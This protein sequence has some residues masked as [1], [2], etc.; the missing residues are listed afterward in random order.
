VQEF[1]L[2]ASASSPAAEPVA[3]VAAEVETANA[4]EPEPQSKSAS[5]SSDW[6]ELAS[7]E[8][9]SEPG[10]A[11]VEQ[12]SA[13]LDDEAFAEILEE[14]RF[15]LMHGLRAEAD[16]A[17]R[18][19]EQMR[20]GSAEVAQVRAEY[21]ASETAAPAETEATDAELSVASAELADNSVDEAVLAIE[22]AANELS[23]DVAVPPAKEPDRVLDLELDE[24]SAPAA[25]GKTAQADGTFDLGW[26]LESSLPSDL[27]FGKKASEATAS[28]SAK[29]H[30]KKHEDDEPRVAMSPAHHSTQ[31]AAH[32]NGSN[33]SNVSNGSNGS[34]DGNGLL[35]SDPLGDI[36]EEFRSSVELPE[37]DLEQHYNLGLA[38]KDMG[39]L[40]EAVGELQRVCNAL[41]RGAHFPDAVQAYTW[42]GH[43]LVERGAPQAAVRWYKRALEIPNLDPDS[44][45]AIHYELGLAY[46]KAGVRGDAL[47][48]FME[49]YGSNIDYRDVAERIE[50]LRG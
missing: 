44:Q 24:P 4:S 47:Q 37:T 14:A 11:L 8:E 29:K 46:E 30:A 17:I 45:V 13:P 6:D 7:E 19:A 40:D 21:L 27:D 22:A 2:T 1:D 25:T 36:F 26:Q 33:G 50:A 23:Q 28:K 15:Y 18:Y 16:G 35:G 38:M 31:K 12:N 3:E 5:H 9:H 42:L 43:C 34:H 48:H 32:K 39:L 20:P 49:A 41:E 10:L